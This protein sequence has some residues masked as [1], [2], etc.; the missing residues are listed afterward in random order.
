MPELINEKELENFFFEKINKNKNSYKQFEI[1]G[2]EIG[3]KLLFMK[4]L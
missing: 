4:F 1:K 3:L 2:Y